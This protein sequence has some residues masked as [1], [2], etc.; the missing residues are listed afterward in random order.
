MQQGGFQNLVNA[1]FFSTRRVPPFIKW[2][3]FSVEGIR[4]QGSANS[5][6]QL[7]SGITLRLRA[8]LETRFG[9]CQSGPNN[10]TR[11]KLQAGQLA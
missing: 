3:D 11:K 9:H 8:S 4:L 2:P 7:V 10:Q 6:Q 5:R 1:L